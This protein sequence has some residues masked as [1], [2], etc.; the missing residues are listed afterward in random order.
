MQIFELKQCINE[1]ILNHAVTKKNKEKV[2]IT[3]PF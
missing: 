2:A 3:I 1:K